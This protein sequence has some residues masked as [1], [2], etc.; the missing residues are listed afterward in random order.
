MLAAVEN[1]RNATGER[2]GA[3]TKAWRKY[4]GYLGAMDGRT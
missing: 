2:L 4:W 3:K 1:F